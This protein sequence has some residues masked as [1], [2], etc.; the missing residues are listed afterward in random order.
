MLVLVVSKW[1]STFWT[2]LDWTLPKHLGAG[3]TC[4]TE[5]FAAGLI[6]SSGRLPAPQLFLRRAHF[7]KYAKGGQGRIWLSFGDFS[8]SL[9]WAPL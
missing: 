8:R 4:T 9:T 7:S 2:S 3:V 1:I 6:E 5:E